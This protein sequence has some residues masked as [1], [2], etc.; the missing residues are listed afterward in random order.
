MMVVKILGLYSLSRKTP[1]R[2]I[3]W[4]LGGA[5]LDV[6]M[7]SAAEVPV[8]FQSDWNCKKANLEA[9]WLHDILRSDVLPL[10]EYRPRIFATIIR[11]YKAT[12]DTSVGDIHFPA[13]FDST[14]LRRLGRHKT[15]CAIISLYYV[16]LL[17]VWYSYGDVYAAWQTCIHLHNSP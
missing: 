3:P 14:H 5:R 16:V 10:S 4:S 7:I 6:I 13:L 15:K 8:K 17:Y 1:Y 11:T 12:K 9:P 2:Q